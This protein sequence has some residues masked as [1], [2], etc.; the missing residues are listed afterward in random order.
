MGGGLRAQIGWLGRLRRVSDRTHGAAGAVV[1]RNAEP[2][3]TVHV[4]APM[5]GA[6]SRVFVSPGQAV[7]AG[8]VLVSI[9]AMKMETAI[10]FGRHDLATSP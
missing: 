7:S 5:P 1:R 3:D 4:G 9:Q 8:D 2:G 10:C 6:I